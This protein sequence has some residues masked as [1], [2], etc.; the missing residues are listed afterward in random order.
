MTDIAAEKR[1]V[2]RAAAA[3]VEDG[4]L[5]GLGTGTTVAELIPA[6][7]ERR[8]A[9]TCV[10]TSPATE[11]SARAHGLAVVPFR[12]LDRLDLTIDGA[13]QVDPVGWLVKG[14]GGAHTRERIVAA[15]ADRFVVIVSSDK[16]VARLHAPVP[17][18]LLA[19]GLA[20]T[21]RTLA[22]AVLRDAP[23]TPDAGVLA[24]YG[25]V[26]DDPA[27]LAAELSAV[28]GLVSHGLFPP[29]LVD[30]VLVARGETVES[31]QPG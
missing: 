7:A 9:I 1:V 12:D 25:G 16:P 11:D 14:G 8:L 3:L 15:A 31:F 18:E 19:F 17:L 26:I 5:V 24:D 27:R 28:P 29:S 13:D 30:T 10:A 22:F 20:S 4:M 2:A 6:L 21:L 23:R